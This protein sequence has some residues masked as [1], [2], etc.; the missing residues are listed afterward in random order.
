MGCSKGKV[1]GIGRDGTC[2]GGVGGATGDQLQVSELGVRD[3]R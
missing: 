1:G 2:L 3:R